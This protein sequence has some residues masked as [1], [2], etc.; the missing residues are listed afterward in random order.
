MVEPTISDPYKYY[1]G[2]VYQGQLNSI[3]AY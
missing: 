2:K 3:C 1:N